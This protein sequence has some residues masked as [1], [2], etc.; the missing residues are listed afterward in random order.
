VAWLGDVEGNFSGDQDRVIL[1]GFSY[2]GRGTWEIGARHR[3]RFAALVPMS[4]DAAYD[5]CN[6]LKDMP[7]WAFHYSGDPF[8]PCSDAEKMVERI[9]TAG[10][11][12]KLTEFDAIG[13]DC[14]T[15]ACNETDVVKWMLEQRRTENAQAAVPLEP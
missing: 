3:D 9:Q 6:K 8:I 15:R 7:V 1:A 2:G 14:W 5:A 12:A 11:K 4:G 10:G 13:H